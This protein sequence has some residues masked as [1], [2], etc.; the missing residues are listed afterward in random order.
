MGCPD[1]A[2]IAAVVE[3]D[4]D[5]DARQAVLAHAEGCSMCASVIADL[6]LLQRFDSDATP[7]RR[8][9]SP[10]QPGE[11]I[12]RYVVLEEIG[13]GGMG[14]VYAAWDGKLKRRVA[15]KRV[16]TDRRGHERL[17]REAQAMA[18]LSHPNVAA[19][20]E[21]LDHD[22]TVLLVMELIEGSTLRAWQSE[23][24]RSW[25]QIVEAYR[26]VAEGLVAA[27]DAGLVHRD[28]KPDNAMV[29]ARSDGKPRVRVLD[30]GLARMLDRIGAP[31]G[32]P[33]DDPSD[34]PSGEA[35]RL[36]PRSLT[37]TS[38]DLQTPTTVGRVLGTPA[39]MAPEQLSSH[40]ADARSDQFSFCVS[41]WEAV[42]GQRPYTGESFESIL[43]AI[44]RGKPEA[45][46]TSRIP[47]WLRRTLE[48]GL[49]P[50]PEDRWPSMRELVRALSQD[51]TRRGATAVALGAVIVTALAVGSSSRDDSR[52]Q[53]AATA[54]ASAWSDGDRA[55]IRDA[56]E[57]SE[58]P[59]AADALVQV[60]AGLADWAG[61][62]Q[63]MHTET[64]EATQIRGEQWSSPPREGRAAPSNRSGPG[65]GAAARSGPAP[66][67]AA[68]THRQ[69]RRRGDG[70]AGECLG[71]VGLP[72]ERVAIL[73]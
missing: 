50:A 13:R 58:A 55:A 42:Y 67:G 35:P 11:R 26:M 60:E 15:I 24:G 33:S 38:E 59:F 22:S 20:F 66:S 2:Q 71:H 30:F 40:D 44:S 62:W 64:C 68:G 48:R 63:T 8:G 29:D 65:G 10:L 52:C 14:H 5:S 47:A 46:G 27:H 17:L 69:H 37:E 51:R 31:S 9:P 56:F 1:D 19:V 7:A 70:P 41:M 23:P 53:G 73:D 16:R 43:L 4:L 72:E 54:L 12:G 61:R 25:R 6:E 34:D 32:D 49:A 3:G 45:P 28:F 36:G 21:I 57:S 39:Y 18:S